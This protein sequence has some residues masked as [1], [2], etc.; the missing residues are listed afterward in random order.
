MAAAGQAQ[1]CHEDEAAEEATLFSNPKSFRKH[2]LCCKGCLDRCSSRC[3]E[4]YQCVPHWTSQTT[5]QLK[6]FFRPPVE[7]V[8][9]G[10]SK[11]ARLL[12]A[13]AKNWSANK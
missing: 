7:L 3:I 4:K 6:D 12:Q 8:D 2:K 11:A 5:E 9:S 1:T 13:I 10:F